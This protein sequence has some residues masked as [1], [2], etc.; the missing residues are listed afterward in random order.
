LSDTGEDLAKEAVSTA[1]KQ[2]LAPTAEVGRDLVMGL[3]GDRI[4]LWRKS[5]PAYQAR[6]VL[7]T[8]ERA[9]QIL[10]DRGV[11]EISENTRPEQV[12]EI[13]EV[14]KDVS[15]KEIQELLA[16]LLAAAM[17][18]QKQEAYRGDFLDTVKQ[19]EP[20]DVLVLQELSGPIEP[21]S[22]PRT[23]ANLLKRSDDEIILALKNLER[24]ECAEAQNN[25]R[26]QNNALITARGRML[27][28]ILKDPDKQ[29]T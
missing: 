5:K 2:L 4:A 13:L 6:Q 20:L 18:P 28:A 22:A 17:D 24:L 16:R 27:L 1:V 29:S 15:A 9:R 3:A 23:L 8:A 19:L 26:I 11:E 12:E 7:E 21:S 14:A 25:H 10:V